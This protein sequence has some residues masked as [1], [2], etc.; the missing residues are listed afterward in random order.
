MRQIERPAYFLVHEAR[1]GTGMDSPALVRSIRTRNRDMPVLHIG[2]V[3][4]P[5]MPS[6][7]H[8]LAESFTADQLLEMVSAIVAGQPS[9]T[10][11]TPEVLPGE[12]PE[13]I[14]Q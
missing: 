1:E 6:N 11:V 3:P 2:R 4:I 14:R 5:G 10:A 7:V 13:A 8:H 9:A 12:R